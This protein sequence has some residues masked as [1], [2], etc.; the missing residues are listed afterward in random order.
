MGLTSAIVHNLTRNL[1]NNI[2]YQ[3]G[4]AVDTSAKIVVLIGDSITSQNDS[5]NDKEFNSQG[6]MTWLNALTGQRYYYQPSHNLGASGQSISQT[7]TNITDLAALD[8]APD[9]VFWIPFANDIVG[10]RTYEDLISDFDDIV[11]YVTGTIG[12][13]MVIMTPLPRTQDDGDPLST[14]EQTLLDQLKS[15][16]LALNVSGVTTINVYDNMSDGSDN[17]DTALFDN[18]SGKYLHPNPAGAYQMAVD[19]KA[20]LDPVYGSNSVPNMS[21]SALTINSDMSGTGGTENSA[22][23]HATIADGWN[24]YSYSG[25][26][27]SAL[28]TLDDKQSLNL[29]YT[30]SRT[31]DIWELQATDITSGFAEG[32]KYYMEAEIEILNASNVRS[33][34][35]IEPTLNS[36]GSY[37]AMTPYDVNAWPDDFTGTIHLRTPIFTIGASDTNIDPIVWA[38]MNSIGVTSN[39]EVIIKQ[40][41]FVDQSDLSVALSGDSTEEYH[42]TQYSGAGQAGFKAQAANYYGG[43]ITA[44]D[45]ARSGSFL[46]ESTA[47]END[48]GNTNLFWVDDSAALANGNQI[49]NNVVNLAGDYDLYICSLGINDHVEVVGAL[50]TASDMQAGYEYLA[51][52]ID[53]EKSCKTMLNTLG[54]DTGGS[55]A[56]ANIVMQGIQDAIANDAN[57]LRGVDVYDLAL[58]D[59]K[60][61][62]QAAQVTKAQREAIQGAY[63]LGKTSDQ[64][65][66]AKVDTVSMVVDELTVNL[67]HVGGNDFTMQSAGNGGMNVT[68]DGTA[69]NPSVFEKVNS[70][71]FKI[72]LDEGD[73]P[74]SGSTVK[75]FVPYGANGG[76]LDQSVPDVIKDNSSLLLPIQREIV[77]VTNNDVIQALD[78]VQIYVDAR[79][80]SK[81]MTGT[82]VEAI[83]KLGGSIASMAESDAASH[84]TWA[85]DA[86]GGIGGLRFEDTSRMHYTGSGAFGS[87]QTFVICG[88]MQDPIANGDLLFFANSGGATDNQA[89]FLLAGSNVL[90][91]ALNESNTNETI[92]GS[93]T[94]G[95]KFFWIIEFADDD[96]CNIY[97]DGESTPSFTFNPRNDFNAWDSIVIGARLSA[98]TTAVDGLD[99]GC[100]V[101]TTDILTSTEKTNIFNQCNTRF[102]LGL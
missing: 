30:D 99:L 77:T 63:N 47:L 72:T 40:V 85:S 58:I 93:F 36:S 61:H 14:A 73:A 83:A 92:S 20:A 8:P 75:F 27:G 15:Y 10:A 95:Q 97:H 65:L 71:S 31:F 69:L 102:G 68:D 39:T 2:I 28:K 76:G 96:T 62:T 25:M 54:R 44:V 19:I 16:V 89:K 13:E 49:T 42:F 12:A 88:Q 23:T 64:A 48:P 6:Y 59:S 32:E 3:S 38:Q 60:H 82:D 34:A 56:G 46:L 35:S 67:T 43:T 86:L 70:T 84:L 100:F 74:V 87:T 90:V 29:S 17:P 45:A 18:E 37:K 33:A 52:Q 81:T 78:N 57:I 7:L 41:R 21:V 5:A 1:V 66:G 91:Y 53:A 26:T 50:V 94:G 24:L 101:H 98:G 22:L 4:A 55:D 80:S 51:T 9:L 11:T 79:G